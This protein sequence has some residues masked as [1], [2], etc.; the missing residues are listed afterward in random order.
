MK[1]GGQGYLDWE[2]MEQMAHMYQVNNVR[3]NNAS[4]QEKYSR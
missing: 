1:N 4:I 2:V 3:K